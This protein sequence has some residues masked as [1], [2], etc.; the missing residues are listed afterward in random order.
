MST[1][2]LQ[3]AMSSL[4]IRLAEIQSR[5]DQ[6]ET[7]INQFRTQLRRLP[8]QVVYGTISLDASLAAMGEIEERLNDA[9]ATH[10]WLLE[11]KKTAI[12][13]LEAL[14]LVGQV[15]EARRSLSSL[16]QQNLLSGETEESAAEI[17][18]LEKFIAEYSKRAELAITDSYQERQ[19]LK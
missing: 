3:I 12:Y 15:D 10:R 14:Q 2:Q 5:E 18:R 4:R 7:L 9:I 1:S 11:F 6:A 19:G 8:R 13:E 16:R 17:L